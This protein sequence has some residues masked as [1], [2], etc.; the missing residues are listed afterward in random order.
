MLRQDL[1]LDPSIRVSVLEVEAAGRLTVYRT[2][3]W[4]QSLLS[5]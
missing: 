1:Y 2:G 5:W 3:S 4:Y